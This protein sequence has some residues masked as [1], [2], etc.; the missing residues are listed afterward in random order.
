M[1]SVFIKPYNI[2]RKSTY[3]KSLPTKK[4]THSH[5]TRSRKKY[6]AS[7]RFKIDRLKK[8]SSEVLRQE[9]YHKKI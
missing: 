2:I 7:K 8:V 3:M 5:Q 6:L 9:K 4:N 1:K